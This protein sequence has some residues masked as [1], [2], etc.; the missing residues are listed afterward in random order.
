MLLLFVIRAVAIRAAS[1]A[2]AAHRWR[3]RAQFWGLR[4]DTEQFN[5][6]PVLFKMKVD[7]TVT[8]SRASQVI[9]IEL[10]P[11]SVRI[12]DSSAALIPYREII[13]RGI[14]PVFSESRS[15]RGLPTVT[16]DSASVECFDEIRRL[17]S[18]DEKLFDDGILLRQMRVGSVVVE[19][20]R[21]DK[22]IQHDAAP[23]VS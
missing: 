19:L 12:R 23:I 15:V 5:L 18:L 10:S 7:R 6:S 22:G 14:E 11:F 8:V 20:V 13:T 9:A 3:C 21:I 4:I 1:F 17:G 16:I 2:G